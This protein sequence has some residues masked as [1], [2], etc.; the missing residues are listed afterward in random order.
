MGEQLRIFHLL[1]EHDLF[2]ESYGGAVSRWV[3]NI[4]RLDDS[5]VVVTTETDGTWNISAER[6]LMVPKLKHYRR[7]RQYVGSRK[8]WQV[9]KLLIR[10]FFAPLIDAAG[11]GDLVW[12]HNRPESA[13]AIAPLLKKKGAKM[14]LHMHNSHVRYATP[15]MERE[16]AGVQM[17]YVSRFLQKEAEGLSAIWANGIVLYNG[18]DGSL[19]RPKPPLDLANPSSKALRILLVGRLVHDKGAHVLVEALKR[20]SDR[21]VP[22]IGVIVGAGGFRNSV[23]SPY[24]RQLKA[25]AAANTEFRGHLAGQ[26]LLDEFQRADVF[27]APSVWDEPFGLVL[28]EAM[29]SGLPV[30][31]AR[32]GGMPEALQYGGGVII[33]KSSVEALEEAIES[34]VNNPELRLAIARQ[35]IE[36]FEKYFTWPIVFREYRSIVERVMAPNSS[37]R[38]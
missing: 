8:F 6:V 17:V 32:S 33:E 27:C 37:S 20:L 10:H 12:V 2:S 29:A 36:S 34:F 13:A 15:P 22:V 35:G 9:R 14:V 3:A 23:D 24:V 18:T 19:F 30:I 5:V 4:A 38:P 7:I 26:P 25:D 21:A 31:A 28:L 1:S 16:L 11:P